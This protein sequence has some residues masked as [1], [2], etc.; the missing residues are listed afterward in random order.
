MGGCCRTERCEGG[1]SGGVDCGGG[2]GGGGECGGEGGD[3]T[4]ESS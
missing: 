4:G 3:G 1:G 2:G